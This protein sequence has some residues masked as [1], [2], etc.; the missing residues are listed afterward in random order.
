MDSKFSS[1]DFVRLTLALSLAVSACGESTDK[2]GPVGDGDSGDGDVSP[3][4]GDATPGDGDGDTTPGDG[5]GDGP[6]EALLPWKQGNTWTYNV[7]NN[8]VVSIKTVTVGAEEPV[9]GDGPNKDKLAFKITTSK[10]ES[11]QTVSWQAVLGDHVVRYREQ[12]FS[13]STGELAL[14]EYWDPYKIHIDGSAEHRVPGAQWVEEYTEFKVVPG[15]PATSAEASDTWLVDGIQEV[16][17]PAGTFQ[18]VVLQKTG[19]TSTK[20]YWYVPGVGK[21]KETGGQ[22]EELVEFELTP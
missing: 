22:T 6:L 13:A 14:E 1:R 10:G 4:D 11:D 7:T 12:S 18:A 21:V 8:G 15:M 5:D 17:V 2:P 20:R 9:G 16:S 19:A 3:G